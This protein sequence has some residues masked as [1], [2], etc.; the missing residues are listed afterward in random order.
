[1]APARCSACEPPSSHAAA[2]CR[3]TSARAHSSSTSAASTR[4]SS[5]APSELRR[6]RVA[7]DAAAGERRCR[8]VTVLGEPGIGKTRLGRELVETVAGEA[9]TLV[10]RC[11]SYG[12]RLTFMPLSSTR[13][14]ASLSVQFWLLTQTA[15]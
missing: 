13:F 5:A 15:S 8:V 12:R 6:L 2:A 14:A 4:L 1:M 9:E 7:F 3:R 11:V 10:G